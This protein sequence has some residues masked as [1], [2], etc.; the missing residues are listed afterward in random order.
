MMN[1]PSQE[2]GTHRRKQASWEAKNQR[3]CRSEGG[4][5]K[6]PGLVQ[7]A[8]LKTNKNTSL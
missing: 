7:E 8:L 4:E 3:K 2:G 6:N 5:E 1:G